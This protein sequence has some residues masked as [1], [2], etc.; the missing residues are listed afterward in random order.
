M[1]RGTKPVHG[2]GVNDST[3]PIDGFIYVSW[4]G[5]IRRSVENRDVSVSNDWLSLSSYEDWV[6]NQPAYPH[7]LSKE[8][9][10]R[11]FHVDKDILSSRKEYSAT[12]CCIV[13]QW[14]NKAVTVKPCANDL[15]IGVSYRKKP[16]RLSRE[17]TNPYRAVVYSGK[18]VSL[19]C[20]ATPEQAHKKWQVAKVEHLKQVIG[21]YCMEP[22]KDQRVVSKL[23]EHMERIRNDHIH[24]RITET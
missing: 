4:A 19:G 22:Y 11:Y 10:K 20:Y 5:L 2:V 16:E 8:Y 21:T 3:C 14:I 24:N 6:V 9:P 13:P 7:C 12:N 23:F 18:H 15:P 1:K 17:H